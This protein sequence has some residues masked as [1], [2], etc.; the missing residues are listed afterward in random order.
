ML[1]C[2]YCLSLWIALP[3][4]IWIGVSWRE[5]ALLWPALSAGA[6]LLERVISTERAAVPAACHLGNEEDDNVLFGKKNH[7]AVERRVPA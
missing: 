4:A 2:F 6:I 1:D 7:H 5:R 3:L